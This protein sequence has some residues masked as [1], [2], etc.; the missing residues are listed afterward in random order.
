[1]AIHQEN[2]LLNSPVDGIALQGTY[3]YP[4]A[5]RGIVQFVHGMAEHRGRYFGVMTAL[6]EAGFA[7]VIHDHR[8]HGDCPLTGHFGEGGKEGMIADTR[9]VSLLAKGKFPSIPFWLFGHSMGSLVARCYL[10]RYDTELDGLFLCGTPYAPPM[11]IKAAQILIALKIPFQGDSHRSHMIN[12]LVT[13]AFNKAIRDP[14]SPN[15]WIS[16]NEENVAAYDADPLCGFCFTLSGFKGLMGL[17]AE[18][19]SARN[20]NVRNPQLPIRFLSGEDDPCH[21]GVKNFDWAALQLY[22]SGYD[23]VE[24]KLFPAMRH[25]ILLEQDHQKVYTYIIES[26]EEFIK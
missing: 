11:A 8:G 26:L 14:A 23:G 1:M 24:R 17:M 7:A 13:G 22:R 12:G 9:Q 19:Y 4:D 10:K 6:A 15:Q 21:G 25:E 18:A 20:W 2:F 3:I 5:P 16:Y